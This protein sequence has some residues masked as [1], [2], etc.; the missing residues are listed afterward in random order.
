[1]NVLWFFFLDAHRLL[2]DDPFPVDAGHVFWSGVISCSFSLYFRSLFHWCSLPHRCHM[3]LVD[4]RQNPKAGSDALVFRVTQQRAWDFQWLRLTGLG[5][6]NL[7]I[8]LTGCQGCSAVC[9]STS[10]HLGGVHICA[11]MCM[12]TF[13]LVS[14]KYPLHSDKLT[15][16]DYNWPHEQMLDCLHYIENIKQQSAKTS[17]WNDYVHNFLALIYLTFFSCSRTIRLCFAAFSSIPAVNQ[18]KKKSLKT[19]YKLTHLKCQK[20]IF[21]KSVLHLQ[22]LYMIFSWIMKTEN[23]HTEKS[24][25]LVHLKCEMTTLYDMQ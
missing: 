8:V 19:K 7:R 9:L 11:Y 18:K 24:C 12:V 13:W 25:A 20:G 23:F 1:M 4:T 21:Y 15:W 2:L 5:M 6:S 14:V 10:V 17:G 3:G 22:A 16:V